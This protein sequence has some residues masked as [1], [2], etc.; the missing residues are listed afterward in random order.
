MWL[1]QFRS[2]SGD[3]YEAIFET[4]PTK[5][6]LR[7]YMILNYSGEIEDGAICIYTEKVSKMA[8]D[9]IP[10]EEALTSQ[11]FPQPNEIEWLT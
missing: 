11:G 8:F 10:S 2:E 7:R 5:E 1:A 6:E 4:E 3:S 9:K